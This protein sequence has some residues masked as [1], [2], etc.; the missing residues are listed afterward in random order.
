MWPSTLG[1]T[2]NGAPSQLG[3]GLDDRIGHRHADGLGGPLRL[4]L[5]T[6]SY[7][8]N[9]PSRVAMR[10][11]RGAADGGPS[12]TQEASMRTVSL[13]YPARGPME[14]VSERSSRSS[15]RVSHRASPPM[16]VSSSLVVV[17]GIRS[18]ISSW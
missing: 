7:W 2:M 3:A 13:E 11:T 16:T 6:R 10:T 1:M 17:A 5:G 18:G 12:F 14:P 4:R 8:W 9:V 15:A